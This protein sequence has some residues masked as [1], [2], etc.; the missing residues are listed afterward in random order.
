MYIVCEHK[1]VFEKKLHSVKFKWAGMSRVNEAAR[2]KGAGE[3]E[4]ALPSEWYWED[5]GGG[6][7]DWAGMQRTWLSSFFVS[8]I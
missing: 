3:D 2:L 8:V 6:E 7:T 5:A 4:C 1:Y